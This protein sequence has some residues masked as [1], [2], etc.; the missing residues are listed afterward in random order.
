MTPVRPSLYTMSPLPARG[1]PSG[2]ML[3]R[4]FSE[5]GLLSDV[6]KFASW[7]DGDDDEPRSDKSDAPPPP[8]PGP[9]APGP[10][11]A[12]KPVPLR[13]DEVPEATLAE[14]KEEGERGGGEG[15][16]RARSAGQRTVESW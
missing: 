9:G 6:P 5:P 4:L 14:V 15:Q 16:M 1:A 11:R 7:G 3:T 13:A 8:P 12:A 10:A 2:T